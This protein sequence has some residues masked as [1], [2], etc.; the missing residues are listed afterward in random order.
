[1]IRSKNPRIDIEALRALVAEEAAHM[2]DPAGS[3]RISKLAVELHLQT[4]EQALAAAEER[5]VPRTSWPENLQIFPFSASR[6]L[7]ALALRILG[8]AMRDQQEVNAALIRSQRETIAL[9]RALL[10]QLREHDPE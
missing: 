8:L 1:V 2:S 9:I 4:V 7:R 5:S 3:P 6:R 10:N